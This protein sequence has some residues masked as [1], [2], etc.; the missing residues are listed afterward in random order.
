MADRASE[1]HLR[2]KLTEAA[3]GG[4]RAAFNTLASHYRPLLFALAFLRTSHTE[5][6]EDLVQ[7]ILLKA[8]EKLPTLHSPA[9]FL[10]WLKTITANACTSWHRRSQFLPK[11]LDTEAASHLTSDRGRPLEQLL[12]REQQ[13]ELHDALLMLPEANRI[14]LLMHVWGGSSYEDIA[15]SVG[16]PATTVEGRIYRARRQ[17]ERLL[18]DAPAATSKRPIG[19]KTMSQEAFLP[20]IARADRAQPPALAL[21][22][23][24]FSIMI[25]AGVSIMR[26]LDSLTEAPLPYG[27]AAQGIMA[28]VENGATLSEAMSDRPDLFSEPYIMMIRAGELGKI[29]D[30]TLRRMVKVMTKE[31]QLACRCP[32]GEEPLLLLHPAGTPYPEDWSKMSE[33]QRTVTLALFFE[34]FGMLLQSGV[35]IL[36]T[37]ETLTSLL[38]A[39]QRAGWAQVRQAVAEG[40]PM[41][42]AMEA[43]GIF[44]RLVLA[45][46][47]AGEASGSL[48]TIC[49]RLS[50]AFEDDLDYKQ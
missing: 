37:M 28:R 22:T 30:E 15:A 6:A 1:N 50:E 33:Y 40:K 26:S 10:P 32:V 49:Y 20:L 24:R 44:P 14:S 39:A 25:D 16:V 45:M 27:P 35:P 29:L 7:E 5:E 3:Q 4:D 13:R 48:D 9:L 43:M 17:L 31:W 19:E 12:Q 34:T 42:S 46:T 38:P 23:R 8:W 41:Y 11:L 2:T 47:R 36:R 21:F 18:R